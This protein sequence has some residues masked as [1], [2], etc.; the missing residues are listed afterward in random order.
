MSTKANGAALL[1]DEA[2]IIEADELRPLIGEAQERGFVLFE[3]V[4]IALEELELTKEQLQELHSY[5]DEQGI[6][7]L[8]SDGKPVD[9]EGARVELAARQRAQPTP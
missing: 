7:V 9:S 6:E 5:L 8:G 1:A 2:P 3:H 4:A